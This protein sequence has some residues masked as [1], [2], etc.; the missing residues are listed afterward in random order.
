LTSEEDGVLGDWWGG[1]EGLRL[2]TSA[3]TSPQFCV[4]DLLDR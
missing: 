4:G 2:K 3:N 1:S